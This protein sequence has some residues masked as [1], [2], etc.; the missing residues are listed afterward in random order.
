MTPVTHG[1]RRNRYTD[2]FYGAVLDA[3]PLKPRI[4]VCTIAHT[5]WTNQRLRVMRAGHPMWIDNPHYH[6]ATTE[7]IGNTIKELVK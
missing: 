4:L 6:G 7:N 3:I 1:D 5:L 2:E